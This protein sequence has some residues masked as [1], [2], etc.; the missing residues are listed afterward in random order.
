MP[1]N[2]KKLDKIAYLGS[3]LAMNFFDQILEW[4]NFFSTPGR[5]GVYGTKNWTVHYVLEYASH[6]AL[7]PTSK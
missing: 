4:D 1:K 3:F 6:W 2:K 5:G 7:E